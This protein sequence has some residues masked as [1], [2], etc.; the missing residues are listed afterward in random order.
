MVSFPSIP[1]VVPTSQVN[2]PFDQRKTQEG[3]AHNWDLSNFLLAQTTSYTSKSTHD[4]LGNQSLAEA[5]FDTGRQ[6]ASIVPT[7]EYT[8]PNVDDKLLSLLLNAPTGFR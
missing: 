8:L 2:F 3:V 1:S 5:D 7:E 4:A 6:S